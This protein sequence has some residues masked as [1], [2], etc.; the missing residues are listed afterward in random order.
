MK[1][2]VF[3]RKQSSRMVGVFSMMRWEVELADRRHQPAQGPHQPA[4]GP[5]QPAQGPQHGCME[6]YRMH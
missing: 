2:D 6:Q 5:H 1:P 4:Q 3:F